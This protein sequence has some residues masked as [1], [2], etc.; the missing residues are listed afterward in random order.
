MLLVCFPFF[1][2]W[3]NYNCSLSIFLAVEY[4]DICPS[5]KG[6]IPVEGTLI[7]GQTSYT[8]TSDS[9]KSN[10]HF[11]LKLNGMGGLC[12]RINISFIHV[13]ISII[14]FMHDISNYYN[15]INNSH[16]EL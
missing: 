4:I 1:C 12:F 14:S 7:F 9:N 10:S 11:K 8:G 6:Y 13:L 2:A 15:T 16:V 3:F 5:G